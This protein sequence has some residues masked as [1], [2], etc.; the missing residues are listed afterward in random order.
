MKN[1]DDFIKTRESVQVAPYAL[2]DVLHALH[3]DNCRCVVTKEDGNL[4]VMY[5]K[6]RVH[7]PDPET[8]VGVCPPGGLT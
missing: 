5:S 3:N 1:D 4:V 2:Y 6:I 8:E 7:K